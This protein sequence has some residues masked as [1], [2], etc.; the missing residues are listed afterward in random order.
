MEYAAARIADT[1]LAA[2]LA[3]GW[4]FA[5]DASAADDGATPMTPITPMT[6]VAPAVMRTRATHIVPT[7]D[8][9]APAAPP[10]VER[11]VPVT[12]ATVV[13]RL[14]AAE[15][16]DVAQSPAP[17]AVTAVASD[18]PPIALLATRRERRFGVRRAALL[19]AAAASI[20]GV[21]TPLF[22]GDRAVP[23]YDVLAGVCGDVARITPHRNEQAR[24]SGARARRGRAPK[25]D[26]P[27]GHIGAGARNDASVIQR[28][29]TRGAE[30]RR[31]FGGSA[32]RRLAARAFSAAGNDSVEARRKR[33]AGS[34]RGHR[35]VAVGCRHE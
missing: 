8:G 30:R 3:A 35:F 4:T 20:A 34:R 25:G 22:L 2:S 9:S 7:V 10:D 27:A 1:E 29:G 33:G 32:R 5:R 23:R 18:V 16:I 21:A 26:E 13:A 24:G 15:R 28:P 12:V 31:C 6:R 19:T 17:T 11:P 14:G